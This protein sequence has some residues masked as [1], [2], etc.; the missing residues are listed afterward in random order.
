PRVW[1]H[2][3]TTRMPA[4]K[5][6]ACGAPAVI[7]HLGSTS[8]AKERGRSRCT[9]RFAP[10]R[11]RTE[12][13]CRQPYARRCTASAGRLLFGISRVYVRAARSVCSLSH[14]ERVGVRGLQNYRETL[15]PHPTPLP[16]GEGA[17][18]FRGTD[19]A[20][21]HRRKWNRVFAELL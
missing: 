17:H 6:A 20:P 2:A 9:F 16:M 11:W 15:T 13:D 3:S 7:A 19:R 18:R 12:P 8:L 10:I 21:P 1:T 14:R 5:A 4:G